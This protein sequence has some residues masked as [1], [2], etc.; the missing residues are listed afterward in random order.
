MEMT[1]SSILAFILLFLASAQ[2]ALQAD[3]DAE[4]WEP[5]SEMNN[6]DNVEAVKAALAKGANIDHQHESS[7]QTPLM[8][9]L[10]RGKLKI[11]E[12]LLN[13]GA[14][15]TISDGRGYT[16]AH[17]AAL[18]GRPTALRMLIEKGVDVNQPHRDGLVPLIRTCFG[19]H[20]NH[21]EAFEVLIDHGI[22]PFIKAVAPTNGGKNDEGKTCLDV[23]K[24]DKIEQYLEA[25]RETMEQVQ[26]QI[27]EENDDADDDDDDDID[28]DDDDDIDWDDDD[29][30]DDDVDDDDDVSEYDDDNDDD[31]PDED[32]RPI[33]DDI[34]DL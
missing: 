23:C 18:Q 17:G 16:P 10:F 7:G 2:G 31:E 13:H 28:W 32:E 25:W 12:Y 24:N 20:D 1:T 8:G 29:V 26:G 11:F 22:H 3:L 34:P 5:C 19:V 9:S 21:F 15:A 14:D 30:D 27:D 33:V 6:N 4:V